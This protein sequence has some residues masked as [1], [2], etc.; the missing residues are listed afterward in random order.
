MT[1]DPLLNASPV[2]QL[3]TGLAFLAIG[4]TVGIFTLKR[5]TRLHKVLGRAWVAAMALVALSSF[6]IFDLKLIGPFSPIHFLSVYTLV[7]LFLAVQAARR[8]D[9]PQHQRIMKQM[10]FTALGV[11]GAFTLLPGR[12]MHAVF[13]GG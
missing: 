12:T 1:L 13:L 11:A 5:G 7:N 9:I 6:W 10:A 3:H 4:L 2:I 8:G